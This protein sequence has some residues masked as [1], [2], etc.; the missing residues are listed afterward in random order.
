MGVPLRISVATSKYLVSVTHTSALW[1]YLNQGCIIPLLIAPSL[2][3]TMLGSFLGLRI[4]DYFNHI[5][6]RWIVVIISA[7]LGIAVLSKA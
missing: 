3:G 2:A 7:F 5:I 1:V 4:L 6:V